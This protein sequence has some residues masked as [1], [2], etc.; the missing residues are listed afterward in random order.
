MGVVEI[1]GKQ[2]RAFQVSL[3]LILLV[4]V[5]TGGLF[6]YKQSL[7]VLSI[8]HH[9]GGLLYLVYS[10]K[11]RHHGLYGKRCGH[12]VCQ[13]GVASARRPS[14]CRILECADLARLLY[15]HHFYCRSAEVFC[16][17]ASGSFLV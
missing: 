7:G 16:M 11:G 2:G 17:I 15:L 1:I 9:P 10:P 5:G 4:L 8:L 6:R 3:G 14:R 13:Y 12:I